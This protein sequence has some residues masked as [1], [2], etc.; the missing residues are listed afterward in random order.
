M[1]HL[2][3]GT[4]TFLLT[5]V[6][7]STRLWEQFPD[8]MRAS[9]VRHDTLAQ[10]NITRYNGDLVKLRGEGDSLFAVFARATDAVQAALDL[11]RD[12]IAEEWDPAAPLKVRMALHTGEAELRDDDYYGNVVNR[13]GRIRATAH[14][15]QILL[16]STTADLVRDHLPHAVTLHPLGL[17]R[18]KDLQ[19]P[20]TLWQLRHPDL[21]DAFPSLK[22]LDLYKHNLPRQL[23]SFIGREQEIQQVKT[24]LAQTSLLT[25]TGSG[26]CGKTRLAL[27]VAAEVVET[28][29]DGVWLVELALLPDNASLDGI[30][31]AV[32]AALRV[33]EQA[34]QE[35]LLTLSEYLASQNTLLLLDN[36]EHVERAIARLIRALLLACPDIRIL[37][38]SRHYMS[39]PGETDWRVPSLLFPAKDVT[40]KPEEALR[41]EALRLF[42][43][44]ASAVL[45]SFRLTV[46]N[47]PYIVQICR[48]LDGI[49]LA[50]ELAA[51]RV[52]ALSVKQIADRLDQT[53]RILESDDAPT[54]RHRTLRAMIEWSYDLLKEPEKA[55]LRRLSVFVGG[56]TLEACEAV[57]AY[58]DLDHLAIVNLLTRLVHTS[59][60]SVQ[61]VVAIDD[62]GGSETEDAGD[63]E[64]ETCRY[65]LLETLR[66]FGQEKLDAHGETETARS[67]HIAY[68]LG[69]AEQAEPEL[70]GPQQ[71][72]WV[73]RLE[74]E[75]DNLRAAMMWALDGETRLRITC[76]LW[77]FWY[78]RGDLAEGGAWIDG[79][80]AR[81]QK[82]DSSLR[83]KALNGKGFLAF[84]QN[85]YDVAAEALGE[86]LRLRK[87]LQDKRGIAETLHN[88]GMLAQQRGENIEARQYYEES[89]R[90]RQEVHDTWGTANSLSNLG[91]IARKE[92]DYTLARSL[93]DQSLSIYRTLG[94]T[95]RIAVMTANI[96]DV[97]FAQGDYDI[98]CNLFKESL[99]TFRT[100]GNKLLTAILLYNLGGT[101]YLLKENQ[102]A[103]VSLMESLYIQ[104]EIGY[105]NQLPL[106]L[107]DLAKIASDR[108]QYELATNI[109]GAAEQASESNK[110]HLPE[111]SQKVW[112]EL[113]T[114]LRNQMQE[115]IFSQA[116]EQ[117]RMQPLQQTVGN[118]L[119]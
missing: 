10:T 77:R 39:I 54:E 5:D 93:Y 88:L 55:L 28:Y 99:K 57:C 29:P 17:H 118:L 19:R 72:Q 48:R 53:F 104:L 107:I 13:C 31:K 25:L 58:G 82:V 101:Q 94:D 34:G 80:L 105:F 98:A 47:L 46:A 103:Y 86:S 12:F 69:L 102:S 119:R 24:L 11:Q 85:N 60:V 62:T 40:L 115:E 113:T 64:E 87:E 3:G 117:G 75:H 68:F 96:G 73:K 81:A 20:E 8:A 65:Y 44:R 51:A 16:S 36:C 22:S 71:A 100:Q 74:T 26:G 18:L 7:N 37:A 116:W 14:G 45:P 52:S 95:T 84:H 30:A 78:A 76:A 97:A 106:T 32:S 109:L 110:I 61:N 91:N 67:S 79:A 49:P 43:E 83:A 114:R 23:T 6:E 41:Y 15:S 112:E 56:W 108:Y 21:P 9:L 35:T 1:T 63:G 66:Q 27:Q 70:T 111:D 33:K 90:L 89:L 38:T 42:S 2:P 59:L 50:I 4:V 92:G